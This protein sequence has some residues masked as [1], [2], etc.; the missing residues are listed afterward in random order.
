MV[1]LTDR[2]DMT[3]IAVDWGIKLQTEQTTV[4]PAAVSLELATL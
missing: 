2:L 1:R 3:I 4:T